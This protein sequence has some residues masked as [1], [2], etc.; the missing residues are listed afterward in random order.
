[1]FALRYRPLLITFRIVIATFSYLC[2]Y[3]HRI[4]ETANAIG[5]LG[6]TLQQKSHRTHEI[7]RMMN[8]RSG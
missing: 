4:L 8:G 7:S 6:E 1:M 5:E 2:L 3:H